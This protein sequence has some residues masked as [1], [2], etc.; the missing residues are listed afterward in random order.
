MTKAKKLECGRL[1]FGLLSATFGIVGF[2]VES[3]F[4]TGAAL[5]FALAWLVLCVVGMN[6]WIEDEV[7]R[8]APRKGQHRRNQ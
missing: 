3:W 2:A 4:L 8:I 7:E 1:I 5:G 6:Q